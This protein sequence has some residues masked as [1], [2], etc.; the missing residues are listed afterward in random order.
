[1]KLLKLLFQN[2]VFT[3][4]TAVIPDGAKTYFAKGT[5]TLINGTATL[6]NNEPKY[7]PEGI[8]LNI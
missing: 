4:A 8:I 3:E 2:H 1:M 6:L 5:A 7:L